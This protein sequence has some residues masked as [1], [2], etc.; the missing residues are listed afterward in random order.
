MMTFKH[1]WKPKPKMVI[2]KVGNAIALM[3]GDGATH[4]QDAPK[5]TCKMFPNSTAMC[6]ISAIQKCALVL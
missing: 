4:T 1:L 2:D 3:Q 5:N 6:H